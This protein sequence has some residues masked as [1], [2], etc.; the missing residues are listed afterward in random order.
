MKRRTFTITMIGSAALLAGGAAAAV[1][2]PQIEVFKSPYCG[3]CS[4]WVQHMRSAGFRVVVTDVNDTTAARKKLGMPDRFGSCHTATAGSYVIEGHV[5][6]S[7]VKK[8]LATR[9]AAVGIAVPGMPP[10]S[11]GM[12]VGARKDPYQVFLIDKAGQASVF[13]QYPKT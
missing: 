1:S 2:A 7:E 6:A 12:E 3:C 8:L 10:G 4:E 11:P 9:P 13:A 5:P